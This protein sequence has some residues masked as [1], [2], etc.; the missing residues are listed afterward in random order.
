LLLLS[1]LKKL[2]QRTIYSKVLNGQKKW[3]KGLHHNLF[4]VQTNLAAWW[5]GEAVVAEEGTS[6]EGT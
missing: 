5:A 4:Y 1:P 6:E 3:S 2:I